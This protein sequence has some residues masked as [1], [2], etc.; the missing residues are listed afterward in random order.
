[1]IE[2]DNYN[3]S[4]NVVN[5]TTTGPAVQLDLLTTPLT[6]TTGTGRVILNVSAATPT[7]VSFLTSDPS[8]TVAN[9]TVP[10]GSVSQ[11]FAFSTGSG[12]N[13]LKVFSIEAQVGSATATADD[14]F[15]GPPP[16]PVIEFTPSKLFF[17]EVVTGG[18]SS[19]LP[20]TV[21]NVG[22]GMLTISLIQLGTYFSQ[23]RKSVK[24]S[25]SFLMYLDGL[26][27]LT[28]LG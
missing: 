19:T 15:L 21:K 6:G 12:F 14:Y 24:I 20:V 3:P 8:V 17:P 9:V 26:K 7:S 18:P 1:L 4:F 13:Q 25:F 5:S 11:D 28:V 10:A 22:A 16:L 23:T 2:L 27:L